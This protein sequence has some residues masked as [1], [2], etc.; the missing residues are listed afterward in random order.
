MQRGIDELN[1][2]LLY[3]RPEEYKQHNET[4]LTG[5]FAVVKLFHDFPEITMLVTQAVLS[6]VA[7]D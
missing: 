6:V 7:S 4:L 3:T 1:E 2:F 5:L